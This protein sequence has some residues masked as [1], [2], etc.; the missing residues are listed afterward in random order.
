MKF[1]GNLYK[2][3]TYGIWART[4]IT[5]LWYWKDLLNK[6]G[7]D[8][9]SFTTWNGYIA[10][11]KKLNEVLK[12]QDI[13]GIGLDCVVHFGILICGCSVEI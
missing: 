2:G 9:N 7:V 6:A 11:A 5:G 8:P 12:S 10:S 4:D 3:K 1:A 13:Q